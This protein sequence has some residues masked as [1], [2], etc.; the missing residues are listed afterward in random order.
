MANVGD[1]APDFTGPYIITGQP[2]SAGKTFTLSDH[3]G[4][5]IVLAFVGYT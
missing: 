3:F 2:F 1:P 4:K 5:V